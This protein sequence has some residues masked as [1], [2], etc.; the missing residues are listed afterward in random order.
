MTVCQFELFV[1]RMDSHIG[2]KFT[3]TYFEIVSHV[4]FCDR[5]TAGALCRATYRMYIVVT[6]SE[7][8]MKI[9]FDSM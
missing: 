7:D 6:V 9:G 8:L 4:E 5:E 2:G 3:L 1:M